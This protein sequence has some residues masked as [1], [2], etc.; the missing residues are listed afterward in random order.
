[1][2]TYAG[3]W[4]RVGAF[5]LDY[6]L[7]ATYLI[8]ITVLFWFIDQRF[9]LNP[10]LFTD[11]VRAQIA[12][13][14]LVTFPVTLYF[15]FQDSS[16]KQATWGKERVLLKVV[17]R[18]GNRI[19]FWSALARTALKF[20]PWEISHT[21]LWE[22]SFSQGSLSAFINYGYAL[23]YLLIGLNI[24]SVVMTKKKQSLYDLLAGTY[25]LKPGA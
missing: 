4:Q 11:R 19:S 8:S 17:H 5:V 20:I 2:N 6:F 16:A 9:N 12:A 15:V 25:V 18:N 1:M 24:A 23:V 10:W 14:S 13:F 7:I 21:L 3:F 22:I